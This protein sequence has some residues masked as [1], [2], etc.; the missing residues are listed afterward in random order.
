MRLAAV[1][2]AVAAV[3]GGVLAIILSSCGGP[4][5]F[6]G[7]LICQKC[8][9]AGAC[10]SANA[11]EPLDLA[12]YPEKHTAKCNR[13]AESIVSGFGIAVKQADGKYRYYRFDSAGSALALDNVVYATKKA[14]GILVEVRGK[15]KGNT[16][17]VQSVAEK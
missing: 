11:V 16:I 5:T 9:A 7:Y 13:S 15:L 4:Q 8:G 6:T 2:L 17:E 10:V 3:L 14:D 12:I 1:V